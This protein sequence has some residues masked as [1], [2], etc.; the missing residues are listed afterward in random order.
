MSYQSSFGIVTAATVKVFPTFPVVVT[1]FMVNVTKDYDPKL[2]PAVAHFL[3][4]GATLRDKYGL[5]GYFYVYKNGFHS[6]L[7]VPGKYATLDNAKKVTT[8]LMTK[9]E[10]L[11]GAKHIEPNYYEHKTYKDWYEAEMGNE[12][13]EDMGS[14]FHSWYDGADGDVPSAFDVMENPL[15]VLPYRI[16]DTQREAANFAA[17]AA[18]AAHRKRAEPMKVSIPRTQ[19]MG[20]TYL[21]SRLLSDKMVNSVSLQQLADT[22]NAT[23]PRIIANHIRGFLYGGGE[24]AKMNTSSMGLIPAWKDATYHF[25]INAV[26]GGMRHDYTIQAWDKLFPEAGAYVNEANPGE[27][28]WKEKF[29]GVN[30]PKLEEIKKKID[31]KNVLWCSPCVGAD[32]LTYD[33]E[34]ICKNPKYPQA[35]PSPQTYQNDKSKTGIA[36][37]PGEPG[38]PNPLQRIIETYMRN[39]TLP[40]TMPKSNYFKMAMGQGGSA[41]GKWSLSAGE[42][43][44]GGHGHG[45]RRR[46]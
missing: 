13:M 29:W 15:F 4:Q 21:D 12:E 41:G 43:N 6:V 38:I 42:T 26:P 45:G 22:I 46:R 16:Q 14:K 7:H 39:K 10:E 27:P 3:Q 23:F 30:Y 31:P 32:M 11:A 40:S 20:R 17:Q 28:K 9:M 19:P 18:Q 8:E 34:R 36:S 5:Q 25:I 44:M 2:F 37:L 33:D 1:R 24:M 35:G